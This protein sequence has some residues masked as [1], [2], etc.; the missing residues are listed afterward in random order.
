M[1]AWWFSLATLLV[2][3]E[4]NAAT[5]RIVG[6]PT[7]EQPTIAR[8]RNTLMYDVTVTV[9]GTAAD[10]DHAAAVGYVPD[11]DFTSCTDAS[12][13]WKWARSQTF[14]VTDTRTWT[15]YNFVPG[16]AYRYTVMVGDPSGTVRVRC[17]TLPT[18]VLPTNLANLN[19][20]FTKSGAPYDAKYLVLE[21]ND[22]GAGGSGGAKYYLVAVDIEN[23]A[24]VWY[25]DVAAMTG[26]TA[27]TGSG[28][29]YQQ[30]PTPDDD[31]V[32]TTVGQ[33]YLYE[34]G[35]DGT[36]KN[37]WDFA[38]SDECDGMRGSN[39][40][41]VNHDL[42][43][44]DAT[45]NTYALATKVSTDD[46]IGTA[47]EDACGTGSRFLDDGFRVLDS[48]WSPIADHYLIDDYGY[49]PAVDGG[50]A[51]DAFASRMGACDST[52]WKRSFDPAYG[53][54]EWTHPN[55]IAASSFGSREVIDLSLRDW[56]QVIR[57]DAE[58]GNRLWSLSA[59][60]AYSDW[61][62]LG[63]ASGIVGRASFKAQH[64]VHAIAAD[65]LMMFDNRGAGAE[66]RVLEIELTRAP[67][68]ATIQKSWAVV[69]EVGDP[70][71]CPTEGTAELVP[72]SE[73]V[74][75]LCSSRHAFMELDDPTGNTG[76]P[77]PLFVG[78]PRDDTFCLA[79]GP[80]SISDIKGWHKGYP[81]ARIGE[82]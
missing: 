55:A 58:T 53:V 31:R 9:D 50:P 21:T 23:E 17:G 62:T 18:P 14:D 75:A 1:R 57:F 28:L 25:L 15:L 7:V 59:D 32:V 73:H 52:L 13:P 66:S 39:G 29:R 63:I 67:V 69:D 6:R 4:A 24:I 30:G 2:T 51:D 45:G 26:R 49:D 76:T 79:G 27:A 16:T 41:C 36:E 56:D 65:T 46:A 3:L 43:V 61:G 35:F 78:L 34:W 22:C 8:I 71:L 80:T 77:P 38:P 47:W 40:P 20:E 33:T 72:G 12:V 44:S 48:S 64:G 19:L 54:I 82:F 5:P 42:Y 68:A 60:P 11:A 10:A 37:F 70:I 74:M 81:A